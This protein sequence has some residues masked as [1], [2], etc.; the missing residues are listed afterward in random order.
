MNLY[1]LN[2]IYEGKADDDFCLPFFPDFNNYL[3]EDI[4]WV[5]DNRIIRYI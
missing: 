3:R 1:L 4:E 5:I 2:K